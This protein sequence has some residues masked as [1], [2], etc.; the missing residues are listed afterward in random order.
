[1][2]EL[3]CRGIYLLA[4]PRCN[5]VANK[6]KARQ[7]SSNVT[8]K[9]LDEPWKAAIGVA[10]LSRKCQQLSALD[11]SYCFRLN[12]VLQK[13]LAHGLRDLK[14]LSLVGCNQAESS[15]FISIS[16]SCLV[17]EE[18]NFTDCPEAITTPVMQS[19][20]ANCKF[21]KIIEVARCV[22]LKGNAMKAISTCDNLEKLD[23]SGCVGLSDSS[24]LSLC[25]VSTVPLLKSLYLLD[26]P[27][28][29]D[30]SLAW[31][32]TGCTSLQLLC[33]KGTN[34]TLQACK[35]VADNFPYS[36]M[37]YN[38]NFIGFWPKSRLK[39][40]ILMNEYYQM[41]KG[42]KFLQSRVRKMIAV[43]RVETKRQALRLF[44]SVVVLQH[45]MR[46]FKAKHRVYQLREEAKKKRW[47]ALKI[48]GSMKIAL[49]KKRRKVLFQKRLLNYHSKKALVIQTA[50]RNYRSK[51]SVLRMQ[52]AFFKMIRRRKKAIITIQTMIRGYHGRQMLLKLREHILAQTRVKRR[53][54]TIIQR[55][56]RG[57]VARCFVLD[58]KE[59]LS[60]I[61][62]QQNRAATK[63]Q[64]LF[65]SVQTNRFLEQ[66]IEL[67]RRRVKGA[68]RLQAA[69]RRK[70]ARIAYTEM[71][72][73]SRE[74]AEDF[75]AR[76][77]QN[78]WRV[79]K[80]RLYVQSLIRTREK[81]F[82][83]RS[84]AATVFAKYWRSRDAR[85]LAKELRFQRD[86]AIRLRIQTEYHSSIKIQA[87]FRGMK[88]RIY[89][90]QKLREKKGKW[91][92][93]MDEETG[94]RFFYNKLT[95]EIRWRMPRDLLDL[96][97]RPICDNCQRFEAGVE[98]GVCDEFFCHKCWGSVHHGGKRKDHSFRALYD[99]YGKRI[100]YGDGNY[101]SKWPSEIQQD[102]VQGWM[103]RVA[104]IRQPVSVYGDWEHYFIAREE[105]HNYDSY[106]QEEGN[107]FF[108]NRKTFEATYDPPPDL[109][110]VGYVEDD[111]DQSA[112]YDTGM[113]ENGE[114][115]TNDYSSW[116]QQ[117]QGFSYSS[118]YEFL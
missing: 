85:L 12:Q 97:P 56:F 34:T 103:L 112:S 67:K 99:Y 84:H 44:R 30:T 22:K 114:Q 70:L 53:K 95:G 65:R 17:L 106:V 39:D 41:Q 107:S 28:L 91:K 13:N 94:K 43:R 46:M 86:E 83:Q 110:Q 35:A 42:I 82:Q 66:A 52:Q 61:R 117:Q 25:E 105:D 38:P 98:C 33:L 8:K 4:D 29:S 1:L 109:Q 111:Q 24:L 47:L 63:I 32:A 60:H 5:P 88:G 89:F 20:C 80:A 18:I 10:A 31:I 9:E 15:A 72:I 58:L 26:I 51:K 113:I 19:F 81:I 6:S 108:F 69:V 45:A 14:K 87:L 16:E 11:L 78:R 92:E 77:I 21:L 55:V 62:L 3:V 73:Q 90:D 115:S 54:A 57:Y 93:L 100:D 116:D 74:R 76:M 27:S 49:A 64:R 36:D 71:V 50:Y 7:F 48:L 40:R 79:K 75:G 96:I 118:S 101:P 2:K 68:V 23:L 102:E 59:H 104:P 37:I